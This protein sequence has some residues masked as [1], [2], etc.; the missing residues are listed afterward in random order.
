MLSDSL[1]RQSPRGKKL[2]GSIPGH[3]RTPNSTPSLGTSDNQLHI[4][5]N[6]NNDIDAPDEDS[7]SASIPLTPSF[8]IVTGRFV[9]SGRARH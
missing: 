7:T 2:T 3:D 4:C 8:S 6:I 5:D 1:Q 9:R